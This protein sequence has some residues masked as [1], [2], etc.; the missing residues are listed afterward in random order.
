MTLLFHRAHKTAHGHA[1]TTKEV[2]IV[3]LRV[4]ARASKAEYNWLPY[5]RD[6]AAARRAKR[7][8]YCRVEHDYTDFACY[9]DGEFPAA[10]LRGPC[11][12]E[13]PTTTIVIHSGQTAEVDELGNIW[14]NAC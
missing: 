4:V 9:G 1:L 2:E 6:S 5:A 10:A 11:I 7:R 3:N 13:E 12:I 8:A 14:I